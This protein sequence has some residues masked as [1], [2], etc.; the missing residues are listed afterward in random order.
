MAVGKYSANLNHVTI[1]GWA[2]GHGDAVY[3]GNNG[4]W[5]A[6]SSIFYYAPGGDVCYYATMS[7]SVGSNSYN[8]ENANTCKIGGYHNTDPL[9]DDLDMYDS[10][11]LTMP[12]LPGSPA[13]DGAIVS[14]PVTTDQRG[15]G[16]FDGDGDGVTKSDIGAHEVETPIYLPLINK[17]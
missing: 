6:D 13:I 3:I 1:V 7:Y 17:R 8:I 14:D 9:L 16:R 4:T 10:T 2:D 5:H 15:F 12:P 11:M